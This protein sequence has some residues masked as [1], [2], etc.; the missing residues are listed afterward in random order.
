M[1]D[2]NQRPLRVNAVPFLCLACCEQ[3]SVISITC[4]HILDGIGNH[5]H[6]LHRRVKHEFIYPTG[7]ARLAIVNV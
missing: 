3:D 7:R 1:L 5:G 2:S 6:R 4:R